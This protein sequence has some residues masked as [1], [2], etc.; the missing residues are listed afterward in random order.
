MTTSAS[1]GISGRS[2]AQA[3]WLF[4][5]AALYNIGGA[6]GFLFLRPWTEPLLDLDP[7]AGTNLPTLYLCCGFVIL[8]GCVYI[9]LA[10]DPVRYRP[11]IPLAV[12]GKLLAIVSFVVPWMGGQVSWP[13]VATIAA[14]PAYVVLF[15]LFLRSVP[16]R[17]RLSANLAPQ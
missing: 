1:T 8:F 5:S 6:V 11:Y 17:G 15:L 16:D 2:S 7:V 10:H 12:L 4:G 9:L 13:L 14:D 3:R